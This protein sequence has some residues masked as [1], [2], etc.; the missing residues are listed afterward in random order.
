ML[1]LVVLSILWKA[2]SRIW[3]HKKY[4]SAI[5]TPTHSTR[6]SG[7]K[8]DLDYWLKQV[9]LLEAKEAERNSTLR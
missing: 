6:L 2:R 4:S 8:F 7:G 1:L 3:R 5:T 9:D